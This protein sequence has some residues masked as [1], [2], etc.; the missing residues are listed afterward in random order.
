LSH[1]PPSV[2]MAITA[3][4]ITESSPLLAPLRF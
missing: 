1:M 2:A 4:I 3:T